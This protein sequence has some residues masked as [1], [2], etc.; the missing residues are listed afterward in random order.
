MKEQLKHVRLTCVIFDPPAA[1]SDSSIRRVVYYSGLAASATEGSKSQARNQIFFIGVVPSFL[2]VF[3][4]FPPLSFLLLPY[5]S[6]LSSLSSLPSCLPF[7][8]AFHFPH[9]PAPTP[10]IHLGGLGS[11]V[12]SPVGPGG[13]RRQTHLGAI[14]GQNFANHVNKLACSQHMPIN[15]FC[16]GGPAGPSWQC[17]FRF[18]LFFSFSFSF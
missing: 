1:A 14:E 8:P 6:S 7:Q 5:R 18:D 17:D 15:K 11:A 13:A 10:K 16:C 3:P 4:P 12:G 9:F 2:S